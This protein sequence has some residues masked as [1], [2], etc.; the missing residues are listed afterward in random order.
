LLS[1]ERTIFKNPSFK[2]LVIGPCFPDPRVVLWFSH[3]GV[4]IPQPSLGLAC[5]Y[6][7]IGKQSRESLLKTTDEEPGANLFRG[8][9]DYISGD[10]FIEDLITVIWNHRKDPWPA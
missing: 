6:P 2:R 8:A 1:L 3:R 4:Q 5:H 9:P 7:R 10:A